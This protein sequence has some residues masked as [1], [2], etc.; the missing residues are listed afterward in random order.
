[1]FYLFLQSLL[2]TIPASFLTFSSVAI[3]PVY[4]DDLIEGIFLAIDRGRPGEVYIIGG[5]RPVR[6]SDL[7]SRTDRAND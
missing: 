4:G 1:M 3:Y 6:N 7:Q 2:P 5:E